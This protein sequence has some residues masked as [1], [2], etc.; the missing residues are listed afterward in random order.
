MDEL[1]QIK[2]LLCCNTFDEAMK[3]ANKVL[4]KDPDNAQA[5]F[6]RGKIHWR[7]GN[8]KAATDDYLKSARLEPG[9][10]AERALE[11]A[12]DIES[13]FDRQLYNP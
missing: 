6:L 3:L 8:R 5:L 12:R 2:N 1:Q 10:P 7:T 9:G 11:Q 4:E 13:F